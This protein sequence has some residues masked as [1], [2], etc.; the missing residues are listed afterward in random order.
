MFDDDMPSAEDM[1][2]EI[3]NHATLRLPDLMTDDDIAQVTIADWKRAIMGVLVGYG[4]QTR[5]EIQRA[6]QESRG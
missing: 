2:D 1:A 4:V 6:E 5:E 3:V